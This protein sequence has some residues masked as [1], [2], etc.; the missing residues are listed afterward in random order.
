[1]AATG[2]QSYQ[3]F[4]NGQ[5][6]V[7]A[8]QAIYITPVSNA[9]DNG[10]SFSVSVSGYFGM[11]RS[12]PATLTVKPPA[13]NQV[14]FVAPNGDDSNAGTIDQ[15]YKTIQHCAATIDEGGTCEIRSGTY[16]EAITPNS[17]ITITAYHFEPVVIDGSDPV[18]GWMLDHGSV[19]KAK[20]TL[21][22]D[23]SN[24]IFLGTEMMT[25]ARWPNGNDLF[26]INWA[27]A[28]KGTS[29]SQIVDSKIPHLDW[30]AAKVHLWSGSDPF[31]HQTGSVIS[32]GVGQIGIDVGQ[33][34]ICPFIC[35]SENGY[36]YLYGTLKALD[37]E[38]EW[39]YDVNSSTLYFM[40]PGGADPN[41]LDV[42]SKQRPYAFDLRGKT[43]VTVANLSIFAGTIITD[44]QSSNNTLDRIN[45]QYVSQFTDL[46]PAADDPTGINFSL[47]Q[48]HVGDTGII[49]NGTGNTIQ[50]SSIN[51]SAGTGI[52]VLGNNNTVR[53][54]LIQNVDYVGDY[55]S[56][57]YLDGSNNAVQYNTISNVGRQGIYLQGVVNQDLGYNN[58]F[59]GML[60]SRDGGEIYACCNQAATGTRIHHNWLHDTQ[61]ATPGQ[62]DTYP[63]SGLGIDNGSGGFEASQNVLWNN[64]K[65]NILINGVTNNS[66][67]NNLIVNNTIPDS[68]SGAEIEITYV[69][70]CASTRITDNKVVKEV[71][72]SSNGSSCTLSNNSGMG[73][74][75]TEMT[76]SSEVGCNFFGCSSN[77]PPAIVGEDSVTS[78]PV[79]PT[80]SVP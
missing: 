32:S 71:A 52:A 24:Q 7:G 66:P 47:L 17:N 40:A 48:V 6:I 61:A 78:C 9:V 14:L 74:G 64:K 54:N 75:A 49:L 73:P 69:Q 2:V 27:K 68:S 23:D 56:G 67:N 12:G 50:N 77:R 57:I 19:Y 1:M 42:R 53:N 38:R 72:E 29:S 60:L 5:A 43:G 35:P 28:E 62:A 30:T 3:W 20:V 36:F 63:L 21:N 70:S 13:L 16:R 8:T 65:Y 79:D 45:A 37:A 26:Y 15:P 46:P 4:R 39:F 11:L 22:A 25:E 44:E 55:A 41:K 59:N 18:T 58:I 76:T 34:A 10:A 51:F 31:G 33:T 80:Q